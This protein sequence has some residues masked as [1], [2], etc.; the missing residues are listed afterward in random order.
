MTCDEPGKYFH[1][2]SSTWAE[3]SSRLIQANINSV[4]KKNGKCTVMLTGGR[5]AMRLYSAWRVLPEFQHL[6]HVNFYFGD[7][8]CVPPSDEASNHGLAMTYLFNSGIPETCS[9]LRMEADDPDYDSA[10][11]RY[12]EMLPGHIDVLL[13]GVGVDGHIA[14]LFPRS[15]ELNEKNRR[16]VYANS[17]KWKHGRLTITPEVIAHAR[18]IYVLAAGEQKLA[19]FSRATKNKMDYYNVPA[20]LVLDAIWLFNDG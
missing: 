17:R 4:I 12:D 16:V 20:R 6:R 9:V 8:R 7:E 11:M 15:A 2:E 5:C 14:S 10:A 3:Q 13:L 19:V 18:S 1:Y